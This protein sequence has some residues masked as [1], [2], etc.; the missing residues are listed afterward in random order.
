MKPIMFD[1]ATSNTPASNT[2]AFTVSLGRLFERL[3]MMD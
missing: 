2:P 3:F 1:F